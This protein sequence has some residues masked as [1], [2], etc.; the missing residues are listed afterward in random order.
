VA[1]VPESVNVENLQIRIDLFRRVA[2]FIRSMKGVR[3][4]TDKLRQLL[5][6]ADKPLKHIAQEADVKYQT[7]WKYATQRQKSLPLEVAESVWFT[8]TGKY[9]S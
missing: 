7:L 9:F 5:Q 4:T 1:E 8:L 6:E 2:T 3:H